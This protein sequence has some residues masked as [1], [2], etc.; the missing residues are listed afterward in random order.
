MI[1]RLRLWSGLVLFAYVTTHLANHALGLISLE[2]LERG[3]AWFLALWRNPVG[4][5]ALY[6]AFATHLSLVLWGLYQRRALRMPGW[7]AG[8]IVLGLVIPF[9]LVEHIIGTRLLHEL[10]GVED[11]YV[12]IVLVLWEFVP[13]KGALQSILLLIAW[14]H[15]CMGLHFWLRLQPWYA[16]ALP[17]LF[18]SAL[19]L[20]TLAL[21][22][23]ANAG[24]TI[25][26]LAREG[27]W[28]AATLAELHF[29]DE[30]AVGFALALIERMRYGFVALV[31]AIALAR[32]ARL[33]WERRHGVFIISY[34]GNRRVRA[35]PGVTIL[36]ASRG[37]GIPHASVC[38]GRGRCSTCRVRV[39]DGIDDLD[40]P[41]ADEARVLKRVKVPPNV[42]LACQT[43]PTR[44]VA[45]IPLLPP[46][47][48]PRDARPRPSHM[49]GTEREIAV[50]FA[51]IRAFTKFS[52]HKLPYDVVFVL[53]RY[54]RSM[55]VAVES[56]GGQ[57]DKFI[58]D[59]VMALFGVDGDGTRAC[60][61]AL[62][63]AR[64]MSNMLD[65]LNRTL[66]NDLEEPLRIGIGIHFGPAIVG[67]MGYAKA[68]GVTAIGDTVNTASRLET[69]TKEFTCQLIVS[70]EVERNAG[71]DLAAFAEHDVEVRGR[72]DRLRIR[73]IDDARKLPDL[74]AGDRATGRRRAA[75][76][77]NE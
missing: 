44:D 69:L 31:V 7:E 48:G 59:G 29:P 75:A 28:V 39:G 19:L 60:R 25:A 49:Q 8:Q 38:G 33:A 41:S 54:F 16:R 23:F 12:Y 63:G 34:P 65:E 74:V 9:L 27:D 32:V 10:Y 61:E 70:S 52:E 1:R 64:A 37:A 42:R 72:R 71:V 45:I 4:T 36:E 13:E 55:G 76:G 50:L 20:P 21:L 43:R 30:A 57:V 17:Y 35:S 77:P 11:N 22:G 46:D 5:V 14:L 56:A 2:E 6:G 53:N 62:A 51:D 73:V 66:A 40:P 3:R 68:I 67:E 26:L 47:A 15:G 58:G 18:A 24:Q